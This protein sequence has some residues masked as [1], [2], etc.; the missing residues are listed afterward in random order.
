M[1]ATTE[2]E[3]IIDGRKCANTKTQFR[4]KFLHFE[5]WIRERYPMFINEVTYQTFQHVSV[6]KSAIKDYFSNGN[7]S[8]AADIERCKR[9]S[10]LEIAYQRIV[11]GKLPLSFTGYKF[12][13]CKAMEQTTDYSALIFSISFLDHVL[14]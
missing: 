10:L 14:V 8:V 6:Y 3:D 1:M 11:E 9:K 12:L 4:R 7:V 5:K 13:S 2:A